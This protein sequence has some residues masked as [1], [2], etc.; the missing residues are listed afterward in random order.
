MTSVS[1]GILRNCLEGRFFVNILLSKLWN[2]N[3]LGYY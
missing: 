3:R 1:K 2:T